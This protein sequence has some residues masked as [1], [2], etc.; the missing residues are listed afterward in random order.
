MIA[1]L[2]RGGRTEAAF[3]LAERRRARTLADRLTQADALRQTDAARDRAAHRDRSATA[4]Q[5]ADALP[6]DRTAVLEYIAGSEGAPTTLFIVTRAGV[7][8]RLLPPAD[9]L[10][11]PVERYAALLE[12]GEGADALA[13]SL[14]AAVLGPAA[15]ALPAG[16]TRLIVVPDG[17]LH[18]VAFD[19]L[20]LP[21]GRLAV[22]R[23]AIGLAPSAA[24]ATVLRRVDRVASAGKA[25]APRLL[26]LGD[27]AFARERAAGLTREGDLF[28]GA[29]DATGGLPRLAASGDEAR[30][31]ARYAAG[32]EVRLR[33]D[34]SEAWLKHARVDRFSVIHLATHA[35]VDEN[36]LA[37][38]SLALA[39]GAGEDG[40]LSPADLSALKL[41]ADLVVLSACRTAGGVVVS[42]EGLQGLT[43]PLIEA[44]ARSVIATQWRIGDRSTVRLVRDLYDALARGAPVA[45]ALR[46]AKLAAIRR[47]APA[48]EWAGF[49]VVGD[50]LVRVPLHAPPPRLPLGWLA[51]GCA[52]VLLAGGYLATRRSGRRAERSERES[53]VVARTHQR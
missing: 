40:F 48:S 9:S 23:W 51:G 7:A 29:F 41:D 21:D 4:A 39:P 28:R 2:A 53:G 47:G 50:P 13:K 19:A 8:A 24:V 14:G 38:T 49:T 35:L 16:V 44:G 43:T 37:R 52:L 18:R 26:A 33:G 36:S 31:V 3:T 15:E 25:A 27:P 6:D 10:S 17:P 5:I 46:E 12:S 32:S 45:E 34:A 42:G 20:R 30:D 1:A 22:E 11:R